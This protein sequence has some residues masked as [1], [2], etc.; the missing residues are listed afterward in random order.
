MAIDSCCIGV[1]CNM[2]LIDAFEADCRAYSI[3]TVGTCRVF[4]TVGSGKDY[5]C[6]SSN[7]GFVVCVSRSSI[8]NYSCK[9]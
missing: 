5:Y 4:D 9:I 3:V 1:R 6:L 7:Q 8:F 2:G